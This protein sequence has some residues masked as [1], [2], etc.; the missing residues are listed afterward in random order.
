M[1]IPPE[2]ASRLTLDLTGRVCLVTGAGQGIGKACALA[3]AK[4]GAD[5][6]VVDI[7]ADS[8]KETAA[9]IAALGRRSLALRADLGSVSDID[10]MI[11]ESTIGQK[12]LE[13]VFVADSVEEAT[14][15]LQHR[16]VVMWQEAKKRKDAPKWWFLE[17][18]ADGAKPIVKGS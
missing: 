18:P 5:V 4:A 6:A 2:S 13:F 7:N 11:A 12:E 9:E 8:V 1:S 14:T 17:D 3:M 16:L 10:R 15:M